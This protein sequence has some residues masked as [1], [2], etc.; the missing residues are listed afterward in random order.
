LIIFTK[1][2]SKQTN[3]KC[4]KNGIYDHWLPLYKLSKITENPRIRIGN[5][6]LNRVNTTKSLGVFIDDR[7][8]WEDHIDSISKKVSRGIGAIKLIKP[9]VPESILKQ[10]YN[11]LVQPYFDYCS[12]VWQNC[13]LMLQSKLQKL[14]NR[15]ARVITG[16][17]WEICS[18][19]VLSKLNW[20]PLNQI[21]LEG[22]F[23]SYVKY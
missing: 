6:S 9:F 19:D 14:Q 12:L 11:A 4:L 15:A 22:C 13:N 10:I 1:V 17:S 2:G 18:T 5:E 21:R 20:R 8:R 7:L 3:T 16:D 23:Y